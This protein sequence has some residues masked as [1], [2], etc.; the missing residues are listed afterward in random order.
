MIVVKPVVKKGFE[1]GRQDYHLSKGVNIVFGSS[2]FPRNKYKW[3]NICQL[4]FFK[5]KNFERQ[6]VLK[7]EQ[8][9]VGQQ[10]PIKMYAQVNVAYWDFNETNQAKIFYYP[11]RWRPR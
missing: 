7:Y 4:L 8:G 1:F 6:L 11:W 9:C 5:K 10:F 3:K 2:A